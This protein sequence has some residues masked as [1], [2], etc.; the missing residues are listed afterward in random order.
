[1]EYR[2][3]DYYHLVSG[4]GIYPAGGEV[5]PGER[6]AGVGGCRKPDEHRLLKMNSES[7]STA[8][9]SITSGGKSRPSS[10]TASCGT[11]CTTVDVASNS[12]S[13]RVPRRVISV[14]RGTGAP[15]V[16]DRGAGA[17]GG[18]GPVSRAKLKTVKL[19]AAVVL[20]YFI[21]WSPFFVSHLW[22]VWDNEAPYEGTI[23]TAVVQDGT[24]TKKV[25][26]LPSEL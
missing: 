21:C 25:R 20:S 13:S 22:S 5:S 4:V 15:G 26:P 16:G 19:T 11:A 1:M 18:G 12:S 23:H 2:L 8:T 17:G 9:T 7:G 24:K 14:R 10:S 6:N 3:Y